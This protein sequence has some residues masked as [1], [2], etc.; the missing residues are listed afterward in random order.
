MIQF[1][2]NA[3]I[4]L[5][6][7]WMDQKEFALCATIFASRVLNGRIFVRVA[8][9]LRTEFTITLQTNATAQ[10]VLPRAVK[11]AL[12]VLEY[13]VIVQFATYR[14]ALNVVKGLD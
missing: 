3:T 8:V 13:L 4:I 12:N 5:S 2:R 7:K 9:S 10:S 11:I 14:I 6:F 1:A